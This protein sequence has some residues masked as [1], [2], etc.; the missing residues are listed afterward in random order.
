MKKIFLVLAV[1]A[2]L[3]LASPVLAGVTIEAKQVGTSHFVQVE[4]TMDVGD[5]NIPRAFALDVSVNP[6]AAGSLN[7]TRL[8]P[9][10]YVSLGGTVV[11]DGNV[12]TWGPQFVNKTPGGF[13][14]EM[15]S[16]WAAT[17]PCGHTAQPKSHGTLFQFVVGNTCDVT[18]AENAL[19]GGIDS[20][21]VVMEDTI[22]AQTKFPKSYATLKGVHVTTDGNCLYVGR[23]FD[24]NTSGFAGLTVTQAMVDKWNYLGMPNCW[25]CPGQK[26]GNGIYAGSSANRPDNA[27]LNAIRAASAWFKQYNQAGYVACSD[28]DLSGRLD[29]TDLNRVRNA[30][31][32]MQ[33]VGGGSGCP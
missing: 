19:R 17:D 22:D 11:V 8:D 32:W 6:P 25:C 5:P 16:L 26:R 31:N 10:F 15:G 30:A 1:L 27:D 18:L 4:Y 14:V 13:T 28:V 9:N 3:M 12:T 21:G 20:N 23:V 2:M 24:A 33:A 7:P 29:N